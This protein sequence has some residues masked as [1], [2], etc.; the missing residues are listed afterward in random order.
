MCPAETG[1]FSSEPNLQSKERHPFLSSLPV[2]P[3]EK[4]VECWNV[5]TL[6]EITNFTAEDFKRYTQLIE[7]N[8][9]YSQPSQ[10]QIEFLDK[11]RKLAILKQ[12]KQDMAHVMDEIKETCL[13]ATLTDQEKKFVAAGGVIPSEVK[14]SDEGEKHYNII[15]NNS[16]PNYWESWN[17][18]ILMIDS[19]ADQHLINTM[20]FLMRNFA[21]IKASYWNMCN[22]PTELP[23]SMRASVR[24][25]TTETMALKTSASFYTEILPCFPAL[26]EEI[27]KRFG[28][29]ALRSLY[30]GE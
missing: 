17:E 4:K 14:K 11:G 29:R 7:K 15:L 30:D 28:Q 2:W 21:S 1:R 27:V 12:F 22:N 16:S 3:R 26:A 18:R 9:Y 24:K 6:D 23:A 25:R 13:M 5:I 10:R 8:E 19:M 20:R